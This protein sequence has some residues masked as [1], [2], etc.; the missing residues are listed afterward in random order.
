MGT[1][2]FREYA[3]PECYQ[4]FGAALGSNAKTYLPASCKYRSG[5]SPVSTFGIWSAS[6]G[7]S[8]ENMV[9]SLKLHIPLNLP[10]E[11]ASVIAS[12]DD[13]IKLVA[14]SRESDLQTREA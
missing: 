10:A 7:K 2:W 8:P 4:Y 6:K 1:I 9:L 3:P 12:H 13:I 11:A 5:W 14:M